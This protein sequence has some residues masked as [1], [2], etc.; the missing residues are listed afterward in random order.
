MSLDKIEELL[1]EVY[2]EVQDDYDEDAI[3]EVLRLLREI[4]DILNLT[5]PVDLI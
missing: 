4:A 3:E 2:Q 5:D 1:A